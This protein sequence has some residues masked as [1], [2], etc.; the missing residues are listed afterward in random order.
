MIPLAAGRPFPPAE[1][2]MTRRAAPLTL[3][4]FLPL[5]ALAMAQ[6]AIPA[7]PVEIGTTPQLFLDHYIVDNTWA[8][9]YRTQHVERVFHAPKK[10]PANPLL[11]VQGGYVCAARDEQA[12]IFHLW[13][14]T[15][16]P[17]KDEA[18]TQYAIAYATSKDGLSW[19]LPKLGLHDWQGSKDNNVVL[20]GPRRR[21]SGVWLLGVPEQDRRGH[22]YLLSYRDADGTHLVGTR[23]GVHFDPASDR[24]IQR[25]HSDTQNAIVYDPHH[26]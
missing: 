7:E 14:Q 4:A 16:V 9:R 26:K 15:H 8:L 5:A 12:G 6:T 23:D 25:L 22:K 19:T 24:F 20:R 10:H 13:Y 3:L 2:A 1:S 21:A 18:R 11:K 17:A